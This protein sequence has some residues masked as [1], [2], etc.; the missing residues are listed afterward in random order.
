MVARVDDLV[1]GLD[2]LT[3]GLDPFQIL[4]GQLLQN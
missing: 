3:V 2:G 4:C 1:G